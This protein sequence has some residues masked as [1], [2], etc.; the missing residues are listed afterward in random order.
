MSTFQM[1]EFYRVKVT[2]MPLTN[3]V[4]YNTL[5]NEFSFQSGYHTTPDMAK[6]L[7]KNINFIEPEK[8]LHVSYRTNLGT[9]EEDYID[10]KFTGT[11]QIHIDAMNTLKQRGYMIIPISSEESWLVEFINHL[12][13]DML[14]NSNHSI[15]YYLKGEEYIYDY[16]YNNNVVSLAHRDAYEHYIKF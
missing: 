8:C 3:N 10:F 6:I 7:M 16:Q 13:V 2:R 5:S 11:I 14:A 15:T 1:N 4:T 9:R 12:E